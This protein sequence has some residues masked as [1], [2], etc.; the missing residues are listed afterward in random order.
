MY[1]DFVFWLS[2]QRGRQAVEVGL[3]LRWSKEDGIKRTGRGM[4]QNLNSKE[5]RRA[6]AGGRGPCTQTACDSLTVIAAT[7]GMQ[8]K[9]SEKSS[10]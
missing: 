3:Q 7:E 6:G 4:Y 1:H 8:E 10:S 2:R 9:T 5:T